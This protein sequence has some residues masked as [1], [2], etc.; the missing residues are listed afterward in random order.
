GTHYLLGRN[1][2]GKTTLFKTL[3]GL[4]RPLGGDFEVV[5]RC[6][7][8]SED[9]R[10][11]H[12][13]PAHAVLGCLI[14]KKR[15]EEAVEFA[16]RIELDLNKP[17]GKL[18]TGNQRKLSLLVSE[19]SLCR[20]DSEV[21]MLDEPFTGLDAPSRQA[22]LDYWEENSERIT[23]LVSAHPDFDEMPVPSVVVISDGK[24]EHQ[25]QPGACWGEVRQFLN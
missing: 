13:L 3:C 21:V 16:K 6:Q 9:L 14:R 10:F 1:G 22:F 19:F 25:S 2:R 15:E 17:Y 18:S 5:G 4:I 24:M 23:R 20:D 7:F 11:D 8:L 12:E